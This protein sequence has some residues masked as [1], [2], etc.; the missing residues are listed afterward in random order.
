MVKKI[1]KNQKIFKINES[2]LELSN[3]KTLMTERIKYDKESNTVKNNLVNLKE[4]QALLNTYKDAYG[5]RSVTIVDTKGVCIVDES[6]NLSSKQYVKDALISSVNF[7]PWLYF[8]YY[9]IELLERFFL[10]RIGLFIKLM[11]LIQLIRILKIIMIH[12]QIELY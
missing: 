2:L 6:Y 1:A 8:L 5:W 12:I 3:K 11:K 4:K 10:K 9:A 7:I